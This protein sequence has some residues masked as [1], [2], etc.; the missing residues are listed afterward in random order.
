MTV[1][2]I[3]PQGR[4]ERVAAAARIFAQHGG[5]VRAVIE[6]RVKDKGQREDLFQSFFLSLVNHPVPSEVRDVRTFIFKAVISH[7]A[8]DIRK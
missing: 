5:F 3:D 7:I 6:Q 8:D 2:G 4:K 1:S